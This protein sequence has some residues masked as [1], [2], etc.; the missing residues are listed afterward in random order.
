M[1]D[2]QHAQGGPGKGPR[3]SFDTANIQATVARLARQVLGKF[4]IQLMQQHM[5]VLLQEIVENVSLQVGLV[6]QYGHL[7]Q[8]QRG[9]SHIGILPMGH[10]QQRTQQLISC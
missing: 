9:L 10:F 3:L 6:R 5:T 2:S 4:F 7:V 1:P 8:G